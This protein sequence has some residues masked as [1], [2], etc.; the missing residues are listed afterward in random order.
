MAFLIPGWD[1]ILWLFFCGIGAVYAFLGNRGH[2]LVILFSLY[3]VEALLFLVDLNIF[4]ES[5]SF[6]EI[7]LI[8]SLVLLLLLVAVERIL[9]RSVFR[10]YAMNTK[11]VHIL[12]ISVLLSGFLTSL[13]LRQLPVSGIIPLSSLADMIFM[14]DEALLVWNTMPLLLFLLFPGFIYRKSRP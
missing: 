4:I 7:W 8:K 6:L 3:I 1:F 10:G 9:A 13:V 2:I 5:R 14:S 12:V 11:L